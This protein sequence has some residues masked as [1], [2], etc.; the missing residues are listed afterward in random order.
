MEKRPPVCQLENVGIIEKGELEKDINVEKKSFVAKIGDQARK[1]FNVLKPAPVTPKK[2]SA[3]ELKMESVPESHQMKEREKEELSEIMKDKKENISN[4]IEEH[5]QQRPS[6]Q[7]LNNQGILEFTQDKTRDENIVPS[8]KETT[9][10]TELPSE[11][12]KVSDKPFEGMTS[13]NSNQRISSKN[14]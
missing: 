1:V 14:L 8:Q 3:N 9:T 11:N 12:T 2:E 4:K 10:T 5:L 7:E 6:P 13:E